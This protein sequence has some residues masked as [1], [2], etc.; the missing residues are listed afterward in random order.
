MTNDQEIIN[1]YCDSPSHLTMMLRI[2]REK[3][4]RLTNYKTVEQSFSYGIQLDHYVQMEKK[5]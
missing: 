3:G 2:N 1:F 4:Y 5:T